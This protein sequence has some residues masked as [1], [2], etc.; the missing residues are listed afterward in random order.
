MVALALTDPAAQERIRAQQQ[1]VV[2]T[3]IG[4]ASETY[5]GGVRAES[6]L[7]TPAIVMRLSPYLNRAGGG[8]YIL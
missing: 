3:S 4:S 8:V 1:G 7:I 5:T 2:Q 6:L